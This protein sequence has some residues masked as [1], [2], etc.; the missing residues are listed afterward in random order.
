MPKAN[1]NNLLTAMIT[2][3]PM[4]DVRQSVEEICIP[5]ITRFDRLIFLFRD[6]DGNIILL[7]G[8]FEHQLTTEDRVNGESEGVPTFMSANLL[9]IIEVLGSRKKEEKLNIPSHSISV[10]SRQCRSLPIL[11]CAT[12]YPIDWL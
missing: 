3:D 12:S 10:S 9:C 6:M 1:Q 11:C 7:N 5:M 4:T 2:D 8:E